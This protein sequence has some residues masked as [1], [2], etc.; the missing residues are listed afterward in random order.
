MSGGGYVQEGFCPGVGGLCPGGSLS[1]EVSVQG[2]L[3]TGGLCQGDPH[4]RLCAGSTHPTEMHSCYSKF[5]E[6]PERETQKII[7][8]LVTFNQF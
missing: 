3:C 8:R 7:L 6:F 2:G 4:V 1:R 5:W